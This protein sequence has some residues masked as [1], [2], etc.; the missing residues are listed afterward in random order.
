MGATTLHSRPLHLEQLYNDKNYRIQSVSA[1][2]D[3]DKHW[4]NLCLAEE[5]SSALTEGLFVTRGLRR[6]G[7]RL[8]SA[9]VT[10]SSGVLP[11][12]SGYRTA[13]RSNCKGP[14]PLAALLRSDTAIQYW[15]GRGA[16]RLR[17]ERAGLLGP[18]PQ[19]ISLYQK[20]KTEVSA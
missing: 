8:G 11:A 12:A 1:H 9:G 13:G 14:H 6:V 17:H 20:R 2:R 19:H 5:R 4:H 7:W 16:T 18:F 15:L 3:S 10:H